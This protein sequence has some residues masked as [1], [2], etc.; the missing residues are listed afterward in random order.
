MR[1]QDLRGFQTVVAERGFVG[2]AQPHLADGGG[3][4]FF[5]NGS[6]FF[7]PAQARYAFGNRAR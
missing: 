4:L 5:V 7:F 6:G 1:E 3:G 2:L